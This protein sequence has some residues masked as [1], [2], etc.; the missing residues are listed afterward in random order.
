MKKVP[1]TRFT[2]YQDIW[3][4]T[5]LSTISPLRGGFAF[6]SKEFQNFGIPIIRISNI[7]SN[8]KVGGEF[9]CYYK[10][11]KDS[12]FI[13]KGRSILLAMSGATTGKIAV[14]D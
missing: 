1:K 4:E 10:L 7:L 14:L 5:N 6:K 9:A 12:K 8:G 3:S 11:P 13:L 2:N